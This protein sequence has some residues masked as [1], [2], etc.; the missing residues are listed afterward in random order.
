MIWLVKMQSEKDTSSKRERLAIQSQF[1]FQFCSKS[2]V[3]FYSHDDRSD[4]PIFSRWNRTDLEVSCICVSGMC[5]R[6]C[7]AAAPLHSTAQPAAPAKRCVR[8]RRNW[9]SQLSANGGINSSAKREKT[10]SSSRGALTATPPITR[11]A[12][13]MLC[14]TPTRHCTIIGFNRFTNSEQYWDNNF[15]VNKERRSTCIFRL[16]DHSHERPARLVGL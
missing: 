4:F 5:R 6:A 12:H 14:P 11:T 15:T 16:N 9:I 13:H 2:N 10:P 7:R 1:H 3:R 8:T